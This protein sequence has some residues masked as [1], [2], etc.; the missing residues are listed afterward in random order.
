MTGRAIREDIPFEAARIGLTKG[1]DA[2][3]RME[4]C[5]TLGTAVI[6]LLQD[7]LCYSRRADT[8]D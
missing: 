8:L 4:Y 7:I 1:R 3:P 6:D 5:L 2:K